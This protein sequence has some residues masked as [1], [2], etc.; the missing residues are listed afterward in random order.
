MHGRVLSFFLPAKTF[1][2]LSVRREQGG[3]EVGKLCEG[4][5]ILCSLK[6]VAG[7]SPMNSAMD[8]SRPDSWVHWE[9]NWSRAHI[10]RFADAGNLAIAWKILAQPPTAGGQRPLP[11]PD[12]TGA[13]CHPEATAG[14]SHPWAE[15]THVFLGLED[16]CAAPRRLLE[17]AQ[18]LPDISGSVGKFLAANNIVRY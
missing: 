5:W 11:W 7:R 16:S 18:G 6:S 1:F 8:F 13:G 3:D 2:L 15:P 10:I 4:Y 9:L 12:T 17:R 14:L